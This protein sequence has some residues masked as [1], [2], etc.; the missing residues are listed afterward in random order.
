MRIILAALAALLA[1]ASS[2]VHASFTQDDRYFDSRGAQ[3]AAPVKAK[4]RKVAHRRARHVRKA[5][6]ATQ[7]LHGLPPELWRSKALRAGFEP[8]GTVPN[9]PSFEERETIHYTPKSG[10][11]PVF[12]G[13][14]PRAWCGWWLGRQ[15]GMLSRSLWLARNW[16]TVG[17][18]LTH[19]VPGA[20]AVFRHHVG[21][22]TAVAPGRIKLLSGNDGHAVRDRWRSAR[23]VIAYRAL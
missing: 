6:R 4:V 14:R 19:P 23:G 10:R 15:L 8:T 7:P 17:T 12:S 11:I 13:S 20:I 21:K 3:A 1:L 9:L 22:I 16:A 5:S 2:P 18:A